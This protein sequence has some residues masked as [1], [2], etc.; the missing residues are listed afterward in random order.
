MLGLWRILLLAALWF[1]F[2]F[3]VSWAATCQPQNKQTAVYGNYEDNCTFLS[4]PGA[5]ILTWFFHFL[6]TY[7]KH[8]IAGFTIV[9]AISTI[10][11]W[12]STKS[13]WEEAKKAAERDE[14]S[15]RLVEGA[16]I[17]GSPHLGEVSAGQ[18]KIHMIATNHG[19]TPGIVIR[20]HM[21]FRKFPPTGKRARYGPVVPKPPWV[22]GPRDSCYPLPH[23]FAWDQR[24]KFAV[25]FIECETAFSKKTRTTRFCYDLTNPSEIRPAGSLA[26][27]RFSVEDEES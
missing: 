16:W 19:K 17:F 14:K 20:Y 5:S 7:E 13:L 21:E 27:S 10:L 4:G 6:H 2:E 11:L 18:P 8:L 9:L 22:S 12:L 3:F 15:V 26:Y 23:E 25:G 1:S 24:R